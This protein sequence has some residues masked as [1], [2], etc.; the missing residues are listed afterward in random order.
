MFNIAICIPTYK[1][2][3]Y[4]INCLQSIEDQTLSKDK[5][6][7]YIALNGSEKSYEVYIQEILKKFSFNY[8]LFFLEE[9]GV[10]NARN[11]LIDHS[12][13]DYIVFVDDD[14]I[15]SLNYIEE[16][17][18]VS[19]SNIMGISNVYNFY[20]NLN[21]LKKS[22]IGLC[23]KNLP[24]ITYSKFKSRKYYSS[25]C[26]KMLHR[27]IISNTRFDTKLSIGE[28]SLFMA[29]L[30]HR[31]K[32]VRKTSPSACYYVNERA[33]SATRKKIDKEKEL[34]RILYSLTTYSKMLLTFRY[35]TLFILTRIVATLI[36]GKKLIK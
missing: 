5:F 22:Y 12:N 35:G 25:P 20:G 15:L 30:S 6:K 27:N 32:A 23:F 21:E 28:D 10:S 36:H 3:Y 26:A 14:D 19:S 4:I 29:Q 24:E 9:A 8:K 31:V 34:K 18:H 13:E 33:G 2:S 7:V 11:F 17:L 1:P 16:L